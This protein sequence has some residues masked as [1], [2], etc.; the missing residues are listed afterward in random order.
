MSR[1]ISI[2]AILFLLLINSCKKEEEITTETSTPT[3][4]YPNNED[5]THQDFLTPFYYNTTNKSLR[6]EI[7][8]FIYFTQKENLH[9]PL[10]NSIGQI[11]ANNVPTNGKFGAKKG[12]TNSQHHAAHDL[13]LTMSN[14]SVVNVYASHEGIIN[15]YKNAPKYRHYLSITK[16][17]KNDK[18]EIIGK[19]V[20]IYAHLDLDSNESNGLHLNGTTI[21]KGDLIS[22]Y[23]YSGTVGGPHLHFEIRYYK[24]NELGTE[25]FYGLGASFTEPSAG[26]W[27]YGKWD[28]STG[29]GFGDARNH[30]LSFY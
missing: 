26:I 7:N 29:Y 10:K 17:V 16:E 19:L 28:T 21:N 24:S 30:G 20:T 2:S 8:R 3:I 9:H 12:T 25:N 23:L 14:D 4:V 6:T 11:P 15:T 1:L 5:A 22:K 27:L 18:N 13:H